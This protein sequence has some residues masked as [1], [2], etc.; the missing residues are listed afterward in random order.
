GLTHVELDLRHDIGGRV[1]LVALERD[2]FGVLGSLGGDVNELF[3]LGREGAKHHLATEAA[4]IGLQRVCDFL[5][6]SD[7]DHEDVRSLTGAGVPIF[8]TWLASPNG[9]QA[10]ASSSWPSRSDNSWCA[11]FFPPTDCAGRGH[12]DASWHRRSTT[13]R[14]RSAACK[15]LRHDWATSRRCS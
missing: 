9:P 8:C 6:G 10:W 14:E 4:R 7:R 3:A 12:P 2:D 13:C 5:H 1:L 15:R 11:R